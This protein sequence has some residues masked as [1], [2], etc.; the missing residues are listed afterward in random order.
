[1]GFRRARRALA[2]LA[3]S[4]ASGS[5][6]LAAETVRQLHA[7]AGAVAATVL[8][9]HDASNAVSPYTNLRIEIARDGKTLYDAA[10]QN[11][12]CGHLCWPNLPSALEVLDVE[13]D[14]EPDVLLNLYS[15]GAHCCNVTE[16]FRYAPARR[17]Y[18]SLT[19]VW[20]DPGYRLG[21]LDGSAAYEWI[22]DDD[23]FA[24]EFAAFAFSGLPLEILRLRGGVFEDVT[25]DYPALVR[26]DAATQWKYYLA[27]RS[28]AT[29]LGFLAAWAADEANLGQAARVVSAL[30]ELERA[31]ELRSE[32]DWSAGAKFVSSL[33]AFLRK[34][35][36]EH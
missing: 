36:Y 24:Y 30:A 20:G 9:D 19:H 31:H 27:N 21:R 22:T 5:L 28:G 13:H 7:S 15:G 6:A 2:V 29:G 32:P 4:L 23:R 33:E 26:V 18:R 14:G 10:V 35:G 12:A 8:Y 25:R 17:D 16:V 34:T 3:L 11:S 1:M